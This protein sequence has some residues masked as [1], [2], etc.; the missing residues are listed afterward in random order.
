[1]KMTETHQVSV[2]VPQPTYDALRCF[3]ASHGMDVSN[4]VNWLIATGL[5]VLRQKERELTEAL[6]SEE[7]PDA[8]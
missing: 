3:A 6:K 5:P 2:K 4:L 1:M 7:L 8:A